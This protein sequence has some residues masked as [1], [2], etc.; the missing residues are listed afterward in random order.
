MLLLNVRFKFPLLD[1]ASRVLNHDHPLLGV[2]SAFYN[3][4]GRR[5]AIE[6]RVIR[7]LGIIFLTG[8]ESPLGGLLGVCTARISMCCVE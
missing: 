2:F 3:F 8:P 1:T 6:R 5:M 7:F 4:S